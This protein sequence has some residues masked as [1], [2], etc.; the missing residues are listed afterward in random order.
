MHFYTDGSCSPNPGSG[1]W[2]VIAV[3]DDSQR[4]VN[5]GKEPNT[6]NNRMELTA[7]IEALK[8]VRTIKGEEVKHTIFTDSNLCRQTICL[9]ATRWESLGWRKPDQSIPSNLDLVKQAYHLYKSLDIQIEWVPG[10]KG[11]KWNEE[12]DKLANFARTS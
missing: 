1:G 8:M 5:Y 3:H 7:I 10:H 6:T 11:D 9:W 4:F 12:V 2:A